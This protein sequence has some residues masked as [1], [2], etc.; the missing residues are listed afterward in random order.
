MNQSS[1]LGVA[2]V[3]GQF[4]HALSSEGS[5]VVAAALMDDDDLHCHCRW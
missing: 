1:V 3:N 2:I 5:V 4:V